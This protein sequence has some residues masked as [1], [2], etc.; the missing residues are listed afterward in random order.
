MPFNPD[1]HHPDYDAWAPSWI[2]MRDAYDGE[3]AVKDKG[4]AYLP[5]PSGMK[6]A[7]DPDAAYDAYKTRAQYPDIVGPTVR[8]MAGV[9]H[10]KPST[11]EIPSGL[12]AVTER[13][14]LDGLTLDALHRRVTREVLKVGRY[15]LLIDLASDG[16]PYVA[17]YT[18]EA[19]INWDVD[20]EYRLSFVVLDESGWERNPDTGKWGKVERWRILE[21]V[22]GVYQSRVVTRGAVMAEEEPVEP[23]MRAGQRLNFIPFVFVDTN[24]LTP[25]PDEVPLLG[26]ARIATAV[27][28]MDADYRN[29]LFM[30]GQ[31]TPVRIGADPDTAPMGIGPN[32]V[33]DIPLGGDAKF[34][35]FTG[36]GVD[37]QRQCIIDDLNR[38]VQIGAK[39][40]SDQA[41]GQESG[42]A[43]KLR[44]ASETATLTSIAQNVANG[45]EKALRFAAMWIGADPDQV[46]ITPNL[47]FIEAGLTPQQI[48]SLVRGWQAGAISRLSLFE[49]LQRGEIVAQDR[50][51]EEEVEA[52][53]SET[54]SLGMIGRENVGE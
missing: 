22:E 42:E 24:D 28:R 14:T 35:E 4:E 17:T 47:D 53:E 41:D 3:E 49:N 39:L 50:T 7:P 43:R 44:Y 54:P 25:E 31:A 11:Y 46:V 9:M 37:A 27:Y 48:D 29:A 5:R 26:L 52:I 45:L 10:G 38:A 15:G 36:A 16:T 1:A 34:M 19:V 21:L 30:T 12:D 6:F 33:W 40:L 20:E 8:G 18:A 32:V 51:Y 2:L 13:A 23:T